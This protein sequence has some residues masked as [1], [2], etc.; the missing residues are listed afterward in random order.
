MSAVDSTET[1]LAIRPAIDARVR[2][3]TDEQRKLCAAARAS[4]AIVQRN[5]RSAGNG[6]IA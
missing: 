2:S 1:E 5:E 4:A 6:A 3:E